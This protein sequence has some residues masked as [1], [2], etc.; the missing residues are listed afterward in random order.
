MPYVAFSLNRSI[1]PIRPA[2]CRHL[3]HEASGH[4]AR[5][6]LEVQDANVADKD[7]PTM[8]LEGVDRPQA[9]IGEMG[10]ASSFSEMDSDASSER[11]WPS[12]GCTYF[13]I[14]LALGS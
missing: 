7:N 12:I 10:L 2:F 5:W 13:P 8:A 9:F 14:G 1:G 3:A 4:I 6:A 11:F